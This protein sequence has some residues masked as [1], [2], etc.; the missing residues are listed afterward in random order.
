MWEKWKLG[1]WVSFLDPKQQRSWKTA[2]MDN[3]GSCKK[4]T[5]S[6]LHCC[7]GSMPE[8]TAAW[9]MDKAGWEV[10]YRTALPSPISTKLSINFP[11]KLLTTAVLP[12][13]FWSC[14]ER[15]CMPSFFFFF[16][17]SSSSPRA[18]ETLHYCCFMLFQTWVWAMQ[19]Y[20]AW[21]ANER[22]FSDLVLQCLSSFFFQINNI[23][24]H[25]SFLCEKVCALVTGK[26]ILCWKSDVFGLW[27]DHS[28]TGK[29]QKNSMTS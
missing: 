2:L 20:K 16:S 1:P 15:S 21:H 24:N 25:I 7:T 17:L 13:A 6:T 23:L 26:Q 27:L 10:V 3:R 18:K 11:D 22:A 28:D 29:I 5:A 14:F 19:V 8:H 4:Y 9:P 12:F